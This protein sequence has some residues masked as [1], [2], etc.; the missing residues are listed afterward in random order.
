MRP[1]GAGA[2]NKFG[3]EYARRLKRRRAQPGDK[4]HIDE[5]LLSINGEQ[6]YLWRAVDEAG[7]TLDILV[8]SKRDKHAAKRFF[9]KLLCALPKPRVVITDKPRSYGAALKRAV[10]LDRTPREPLPEQP[11]RVLAP[12]GRGDENGR[13]SA[14]NHLATP[15]VSC[16]SS[17]PST[18]TSARPATSSKPAITAEAAGAVLDLACS[19]REPSKGQELKKRRFQ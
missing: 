15:N 14:S 19:N 2:T 1:S 7:D 17:N 13:S 3:G 5:V 10:A 6:R 8:T 4:W 9:R 16:P 18:A 11:G 12:D